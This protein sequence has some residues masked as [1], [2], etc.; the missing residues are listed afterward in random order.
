MS[1]EAAS[2]SASDSLAD[3]IC[4]ALDGGGGWLHW[5]DDAHRSSW[6]PSHAEL[7]ASTQ[8][9][10]PLDRRDRIYRRLQNALSLD[11]RHRCELHQRGFI[12]AE[13][14]A[15]GYRSL[16]LRGRAALAKACHNGHPDDL[17][18]VPGF[19]TATGE[20]GCRYWS[21]AGSPGLLI[22]CRAPD[23]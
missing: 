20:G 13:I 12:D 2:S 3:H 16:P 23:G 1:D 21:I 18:A 10:A 7:P 4:Y 22:P 9:L 17:I 5:L 15:R 8:L 6:T 14:Q 19:W 11:L